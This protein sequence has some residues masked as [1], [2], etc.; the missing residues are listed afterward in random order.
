MSAQSRITRR[1]TVKSMLFGSGA[2]LFADYGRAQQ[3]AAQDTTRL[4]QYYHQYGEAGTEEAVRRYASQYTEENPDIEIEVVWQLGDYGQALN[5]ALLT[6]EA[7]D[8]FELGGPPTV[9]HVRQ[10]QVVSLEDLYPEDIR[11]D[12]LEGTI[13]ASS[14]DGT[15]YA[16]KMV[17]DTGGVFYRKSMFEEAGLTP[18]ENLDDLIA[19]AATLTQ[20]RQ[21][22]LFVGNDGGIGALGGPLLWSSGG[23]FLNEAED[24]P[25]FN[26]DRVADAF[27]RFGEVVRGDSLLMGAPTDYWDPSAFN[28]NLCAMQF[29]GIWAVPAI[30]EALGDDY[31]VFPWPKSDEEGQASSFWGGWYECVNGNS[32]N[33][34]AAKAF[35][36]WLWIDNTEAQEDWS[37]SYGFHVPPRMSVAAGAEPLQEGVAADLVTILQE[38]ARLGSTRWT[39]A[40]GTAFGDATTR[41]MRDGADAKTELAAAEEIVIAELAR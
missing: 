16:V 14:I 13:K 21:K 1:S 15:I 3:A 33:V 29:T 26:T 10:N 30:T 17:E 18:P 25:A 22:G 40:M 6:D 8:I 37:L 19:A 11:A 32:K 39:A 9:D 34:E 27:T 35:V 28:Q 4:V 23:D 2:L 7:P 20:G 38:N 5:A 31:G 24:A 41:I 36:K 12:F